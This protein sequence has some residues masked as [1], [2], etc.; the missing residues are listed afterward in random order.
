VAPP[1]RTIGAARLSLPAGT[2]EIAVE[3]P[4]D[5][6][7]LAP[8]RVPLGTVTVRAGRVTLL[9]TRVFDGAAT[10]VAGTARGVI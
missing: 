3:L 2:H 8:V 5:A 7:G 9:S 4:A 10:T 6:P 1:P